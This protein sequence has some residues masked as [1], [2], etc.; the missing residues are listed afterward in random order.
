MTTKEMTFGLVSESK[1]KKRAKPKMKPMPTCP[2]CGT[3]MF[4]WNMKRNGIQN[5]QLYENYACENCG[6][7]FSITYEGPN[8]TYDWWYDQ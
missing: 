2:K 3:Q 6:K 1:K 7:R 4:A 5:G 8:E